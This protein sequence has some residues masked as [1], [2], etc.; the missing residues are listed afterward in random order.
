MFCRPVLATVSKVS[1]GVRKSLLNSKY[2]PGVGKGVE[3]RRTDVERRRTDVERRRTD[4]ER[5]RTDVE[6]W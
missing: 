3:R 4:V 5:R 2:K 1:Q 6:R